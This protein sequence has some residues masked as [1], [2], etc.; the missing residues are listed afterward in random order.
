MPLSQMGNFH[1]PPRTTWVQPHDPRD[2]DVHRKTVLCFLYYYLLF[3]YKMG[4]FHPLPGHIESNPMTPKTKMSIRRLCSAFCTFLLCCSL[5]FKYRITIQQKFRSLS[6]PFL[7][8]KIS[9]ISQDRWA[10]FWQGK[11]G[12]QWYIVFMTLSL[13]LKYE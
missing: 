12:G 8:M 1:P 13:K 7:E 2:Q 4:N 11:W 5:L 9:I 10:N 3:K 6:L